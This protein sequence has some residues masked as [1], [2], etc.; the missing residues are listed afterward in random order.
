MASTKS[1][2]AWS[3]SAARQRVTA[4]AIAF[5]ETYR[6]GPLRL[7]YG[8]VMPLLRAAFLSDAEHRELLTQAGFSEVT[9]KHFPGEN[10]ICALGRKPT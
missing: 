1:S 5:S 3:F 2:I 6:G 4:R 8:I 9:T 10:W 7:L